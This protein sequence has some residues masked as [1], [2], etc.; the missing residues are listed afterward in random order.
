[1]P[2]GIPFIVGNEAAERFSFYGMKSILFVFMT[3]HLFSSTGADDF[4]NES[5][6]TEWQAL[7]VASAYFFPVLGALASDIFLGKYRTILLLSTVYC[8][9]HLSLALMDM[10]ESLLGVT[11][12]PR[13]FLIAG[14]FLIAVGS[15]GIKPCVSAHVGDQFG[16]SNQHLLSK[17]FG[18]FYVSINLG[19]AA[20][21][22]A[23]PL[24]LKHYGP[25]WAFGVPGL[26]MG[27]ATFVFWLGRHRFVHIPAG[28]RD[29]LR[30]TF[31]PTG[32]RAILR[33]LP[34][35]LFV[36]VFWSLFD[37]GGSK[38]VAQATSMDR[39]LG[40]S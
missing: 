18:W 11:F 33:L 26:L 15:G 29:F 39:N 3:G 28:G 8:V 19:A 31:D 16:Q 1:M 12:E 22:F 14:L 13:T 38:W 34:I 5:Q 9:G 10:P 30:E 4:L 37:Q 21:Q 23:T 40:G 17:V 6:A 27:L 36:A 7:F 24:L 25:G 2:S 32:R 35:Y 20:S